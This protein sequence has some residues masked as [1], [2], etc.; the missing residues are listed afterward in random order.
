MRLGCMLF[1]QDGFEVAAENAHAHVQDRLPIQQTGFSVSANETPLITLQFLCR[2][3]LLPLPCLP[4]LVTS[5]TQTLSQTETLPPAQTALQHV[6]SSFSRK[7]RRQITRR[8]LRSCRRGLSS[9]KSPHFCPLLPLFSLLSSL[10]LAASTAHIQHEP[11]FFLS[12]AFSRVGSANLYY[13]QLLQSLK[14][15]NSAW[16]YCPNKVIMKAKDP[17]NLNKAFAFESGV[18]ICHSLFCNF[19]PVPRP[20]FSSLLQTEAVSDDFKRVA[21]C[22]QYGS[23]TL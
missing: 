12:S 8:S 21:T 1:F 19:L 15:R 10:I 6:A 14:D 3:N 4:K 13:V 18:K 16:R 17:T 11:I 22:P 9:V 2:S 5:C 20:I 23:V 7:L